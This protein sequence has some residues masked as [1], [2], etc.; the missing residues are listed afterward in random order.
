MYII[1]VVFVNTILRL[2]QNWI[3]KSGLVQSAAEKDVS[4]T[5]VLS[6]ERLQVALN[7]WQTWIKNN[8]TP[9]FRP[10]HYTAKSATLLRWLL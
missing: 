2:I 5:M 6:G 1:L 3:A 7:K 8:P 4:W 10:L 9:R